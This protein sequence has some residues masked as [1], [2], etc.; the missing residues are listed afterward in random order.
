MINNYIQFI[1][2]NV[3]GLQSLEKRIKVFEYLKNCI[4]NSGSMFLQE[5]HTPP[6]MMKKDSS[7]ILKENFFS[8]TGIA[9]LAEWLLVS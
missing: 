6:Y 8:H 5:T 3:K 2:N 9:T 4:S 7:M 1:S